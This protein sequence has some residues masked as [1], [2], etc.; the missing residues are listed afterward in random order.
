MLNLGGI[1]FAGLPGEIMCEIGLA[2]KKNFRPEKSF[3][4]AYA[5]GCIGYIPTPQALIEGGYEP[6]DSIKCFAL[7]SRF[8]PKVQRVIEKTVEGLHERI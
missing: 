4:A 7:P 2:I 1:Y 5:N 6:N 3:I 8:S